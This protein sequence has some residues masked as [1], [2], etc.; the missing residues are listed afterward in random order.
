MSSAK[1]RLFS[2]GLNVLRTGRVNEWVVNTWAISGHDN[3]KVA[4]F[5]YHLLTR[6]QPDCQLK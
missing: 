3:K 6:L 5:T 2:L 1:G 4:S